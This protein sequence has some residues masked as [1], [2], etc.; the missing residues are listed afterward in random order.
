LRFDFRGPA[1]RTQLE[2]L[3]VELAAAEFV[4]HELKSR[5]RSGSGDGP[6]YAQTDEIR[7][8]LGQQQLRRIQRS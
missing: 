2:R 5:S 6:V 4:P 8:I 7:R 3:G 1:G